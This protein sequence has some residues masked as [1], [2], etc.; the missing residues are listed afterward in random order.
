MEVGD[1]LTFGGD[2]RAWVIT[3][4]KTTGKRIATMKKIIPGS[5]SSSKPDLGPMKKPP[6]GKMSAAAGK[7]KG[8]PMGRRSA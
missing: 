4:V 2:H 7:A 1:L 6:I 5:P 3:A 8:K